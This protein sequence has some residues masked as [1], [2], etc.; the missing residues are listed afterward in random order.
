[1]PLAAR[2]KGLSDQAEDARRGE[3]DRPLHFRLLIAE[4]LG[5]GTGLVIG[6]ADGLES[7]VDLRLHHAQDLAPPH[8]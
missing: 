7:L 2:E 5:G 1:M 6:D 3:P 8:V 4:G